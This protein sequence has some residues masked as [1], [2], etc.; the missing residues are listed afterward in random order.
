MPTQIKL[1][2]IASYKKRFKLYEIVWNLVST[3][4]YFAKG[5]L[6]KIFGQ[7]I[8]SAYTNISE[9]FLRHYF[10]DR[11]KFY[12]F[13]YKSKSWCKKPYERGLVLKKDKSVILNPLREIFKET[14]MLIKL[15]IINQRI[16]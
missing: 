10:K 13:A 6:S 8:S 9:G 14:S 15:A 11:I 2:Q 5:P 3:W 1:E 12:Y 4:Y 16:I 7:S